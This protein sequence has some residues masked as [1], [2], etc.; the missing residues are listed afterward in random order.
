MTGHELEPATEGVSLVCWKVWG[1]NERTFREVAIPGLRGILY[2]M[3]SGSEAGGDL[4]YLSACGSGAIGRLCLAD[5]TG[6][7][8]GVAQ[9]SGWLQG[10]F[11]AHIHRE[12]PAAVLREVNH[13]TVTGRLDLISTAVCLSYNSLNG[14]LR[15]ANAGHPHLR[16]RRTSERRWEPVVLEMPDQPGPANIPLGV[17]AASAYTFDEIQCRPGDW[18]L[19]HTDGLTEA[20]NPSGQC[21]GDAIWHP[22][23]LSD[24]PESTA[25]NLLR[26]LR[27]HLGRD[28]AAQD[29]VT[30]VLLEVLP[31]QPHGRYTL[32]VRNNW[33]RL[34]T[35]LRKSA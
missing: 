12:N 20:R 31:Y 24:T 10:V 3:P 1:G 27:D 11:S 8:A 33:R 16:I 28:I 22:D 6:H 21:L 17:E 25:E 13:R 30:F 19:A 9:F 5:A 7:G 32:L 23:C 29:D 4:Y 2:A 26:R 14:K 15:F 35:W 18:L 34:L